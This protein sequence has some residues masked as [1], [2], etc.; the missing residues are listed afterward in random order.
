MRNIRK[1]QE[2]SRPAGTKSIPLQKYGFVRVPERDFT[3]DGARFTAYAY[4]P[5]GKGDQTFIMTK[6]TYNGEAYLSVEYTLPGTNRTRYIDDLNGV[7]IDD[8][9]EGL[10][11]LIKKIQEAQKE[12]AKF[13]AQ[14]L[15]DEEIEKFSDEVAEK[16]AGKR[17]GA[18]DIA[19]EVLKQHGFDEDQLEASVAM[20]YKKAWEAK[21]KRDFATTLAKDKIRA[22]AAD[23]LKRAISDYRYSDFNIEKAVDNAYASIKDKDGYISLDDL[24]PETVKRM[25]EWAK[26]KLTSAEDFE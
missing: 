18:W 7:P 25:R 15:T 14:T 21:V 13:T 4:D 17:S 5:E 6:T 8:A 3:D 11:D 20:K 10:P 22:L 26:R 1:L 16:A 24:D 12:V 2:M 19:K 9:I 23:L